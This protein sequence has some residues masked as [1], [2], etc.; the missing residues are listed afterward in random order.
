VLWSALF[1]TGPFRCK[2]LNVRSAKVLGLSEEL[3]NREAPA[4][5]WTE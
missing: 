4:S 1:T 3:V 5:R 2:K